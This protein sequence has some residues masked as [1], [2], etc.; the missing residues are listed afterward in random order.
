MAPCCRRPS[1]SR[2]SARY[3]PTTSSMHRSAAFVPAPR[4][5]SVLTSGET[6]VAPTATASVLS[7]TLHRTA[8]KKSAST[9]PLAAIS[10]YPERAAVASR[11]DPLCPSRLPDVPDNPRGGFR[12]CCRV[13]GE[14]P[15]CVRT[16]RVRRPIPGA[17]RR[18]AR[19][20]RHFPP[21]GL[22]PRPPGDHARVF[23][24]QTTA[25]DSPPRRR[26]RTSP[27]STASPR[28]LSPSSRSPRTSVMVV[29]K[30]GAKRKAEGEPFLMG[31]RE[32][33]GV[34]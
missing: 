28:R 11:H 9:S 8:R 34:L 15:R 20:S 19:V 5:R 25:G 16:G 26:R 33:G 4:R 31:P 17:G 18:A 12:P 29:R 23:V 7:V 1:A 22:H 27:A 32:E 10:S 6:G 24:T 30:R 14:R 13:P 2:T 21:G 3:G